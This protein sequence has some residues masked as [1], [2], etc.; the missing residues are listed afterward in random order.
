MTLS[1]IP[2][3]SLFAGDGIVRCVTRWLT[4]TAALRRPNESAIGALHAECFGERVRR[5]GSSLDD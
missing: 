5:H 1:I 3:N 2:T 4:V